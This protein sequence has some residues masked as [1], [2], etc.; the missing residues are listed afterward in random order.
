M[1]FATFE[2]LLAFLPQLDS[3]LHDMR[4][5]VLGNL[6]AIGEIP[7]PTFEERQRVEFLQQR[8]TD[9]DSLE[10]STDEMGNV[11]AMLPG[12]SGQ[13]NLLVMAHLDTIFPA[14][15]DHTITVSADEAT[16]IAVADNS[17]GIAVMASLP[18]LLR[19]IDIRLQSNL[20]LMGAAR[21]LGR[22]NLAGLRFFLE[23][24]ILPIHTGIA[25][26]GIELGRL[27]YSSIGMLRGEITCMVPDDYDWTRFD[28]TGA[29]INLIEVINQ[30]IAIPLPRQ[31]RTTVVLG[32]IEGGEQAYGKIAKFAQLRF[33]IRS[34]SAETVES[35]REQIQE[36]VLEQS[37]RTNKTIT[38]EFFGKRTPGGLAISH[39][40]CRQTRKIM[41]ALA[42]EPRVSPSLVGL[43]AFI[44]RNIPAITLG[45][46]MG[47][48][49]KES[50]ETIL[51]API[52]KGIAQLIGVLLAIDGGFCDETR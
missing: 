1:P 24:S 19:R 31:P 23:H 25:V 42:V 38:V 13:K 8:F 15:E 46:T 52:V 33:E 47:Q 18:H 41:E 29:I 21:T 11:Y 34:E 10:C 7:A 2:E 40:L 20:I 45:I 22:G 51:L 50:S 43:S 37:A 14:D 16:G 30:I 4:D 12:E 6:I 17:L 3:P 36:I 39:P 32:S 9:S 26:E 44:D 5:I 35:I 27:S 49:S 28:T 48:R